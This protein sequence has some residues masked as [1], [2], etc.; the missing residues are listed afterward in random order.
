LA[1]TKENIGHDENIVVDEVID[2]ILLYAKYYI[3]QCRFEKHQSNNSCLLEESKI[4][5]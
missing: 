4:Q 1:L 5:I 3:Y 2:F